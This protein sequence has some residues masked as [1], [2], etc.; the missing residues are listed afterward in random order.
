MKRDEILETAGRLFA[1]LHEHTR[2]LIT[3]LAVA[4]VVA[5]LGAIV[6]AFLQNRQVRAN[7]LFA[8]ALR[9]YQAE[10][11]TADP[12]NPTDLTFQTE[13]ERD[14]RSIELFE[15]VRADFGGTSVGRIASVYLG[16]LAARRGD[17]EQAR[18]HWEEFLSSNPRHMLAGEVRVNLFALDRAEGR[19]EELVGRL[20]EMLAAAS[21]ELPGD[22][23]MSQLAVTLEELGRE[24][25]ARETYERL[26]EEHPASPYAGR[27]QQ[28]LGS[29]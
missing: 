23:L 25:E 12:Q 29:L 21:N 7:R 8:E 6:F 26:A 11:G 2:G 19:G 24:E 4:A 20:R 1:Y 10:V 27:A 5:L 17:L 16:R 9:V 18:E 15:Q 14:L 3:V 13:Q 22:V 28:K